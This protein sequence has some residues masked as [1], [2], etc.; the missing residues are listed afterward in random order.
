MDS[1]W[2]ILAAIAIGAMVGVGFMLMLDI[3]E[4]RGSYA[5]RIVDPGIPEGVDEMLNAFDTAGL[6]LDPSNNVLRINERALE[7][8]LLT[9]RGNLRSELVTF[10]AE[11]RKAEDD[12]VADVSFPGDGFSA[13][14]PRVSLHGARIGAR[15]LVVLAIDRT[16]EDRLEAVRRDF[17]ANISHEL[18]TPTASVRLI[19]EAIDRAAD[20]PT[21]VRRFNARLAHEAERLSHITAEVIELSRLQGEAFAAAREPV[22]LEAVVTAAV[23]D[24]RLLAEAK[25]IDMAVSIDP[26]CSVDGSAQSLRTAVAN[27]IAN[28]IAYSDEH[29]RIGIGVHPHDGMVEI[30]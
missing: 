2:L 29:S 24:H 27:L 10:V 23:D 28:A 12:Y 16:E 7:L 20:D 13:P 18:K 14:Q 17:I 3:A 19:S 8:D 22:N 25:D 9:K 1:A 21:T 5:A 4:R 15:Y 6:V 30:S 11:A 26:E